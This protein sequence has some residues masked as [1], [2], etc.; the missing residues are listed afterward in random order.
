MLTLLVVAIR[1]FKSFF[2]GTVA[3]WIRCEIPERTPDYVSFTGSAYWDCGDKV[4]RLSDHWGPLITS[5]WFLEGKII[6]L[7]TCAECYYEDFR[8]IRC[9]LEDETQWPSNF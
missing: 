6:K 3:D 8:S 9:L 2:G 5:K 7:F 4:K 1:D